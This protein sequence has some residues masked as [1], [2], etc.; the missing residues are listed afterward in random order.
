[1][2]AALAKGFLRRVL[3]L[4]MSPETERHKDTWDGAASA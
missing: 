1:M 4:G 3:R 2:N